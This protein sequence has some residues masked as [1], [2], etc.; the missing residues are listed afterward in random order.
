MVMLRFALL[1]HIFRFA[2]APAAVAI[3][4]LTVHAQVHEHAPAKPVIRTV[5]AFVNLDRAEYQAQIADAFKTLHLAQTVLESR[6]Y[7][8]ESLR[9][10]TQPFPEYS[11]D[12]PAGQTLAFFQQL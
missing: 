5:T 12:L 4:A 9:V 1:R 8:V 3:F 11:R 6:G 2:A 10:A 7:V